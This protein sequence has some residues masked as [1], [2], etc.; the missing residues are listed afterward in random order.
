LLVLDSKFASP[1]YAALTVWVPVVENA[2]IHV[3]RSAETETAPQPT[4]LDPPSVK[5]TVPVAPEG[6]MEAVNVRGSP[7]AAVLAE[8]A[9][10]V[11]D[12]ACTTVSAS[13]PLTDEAV[14]P[15][16]EYAATMGC[17]LVPNSDVVHDA[18]PEVTLCA[19]HPGTATPPSVNATV[20]VADDGEM[21][22]VKVTGDPCPTGLADATS[23]VDD[24]TTRV[25]VTVVA[26]YPTR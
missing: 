9:R 12:E 1:E 23:D 14:E 6:L 19:E 10:L 3:A 25:R 20:P 21:L 24:R 7:A 18:L 11:A 17:V 22:T 15:S 4:M 13:V 5:A 16:P 26:V 8:V 2:V